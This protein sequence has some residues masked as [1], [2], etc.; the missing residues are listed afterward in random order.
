MRAELIEWEGIE[1]SRGRRLSLKDLT[2]LET[3]GLEINIEDIETQPNGTL[4]YQGEHVLLY[5]MQPRRFREKLNMPKYHISNCSTWISMKEK[6]RKDRYVASRRVDGLFELDI[7]SY[8]GFTNREEHALDVCQNCLTNV[9]WKGYASGNP[10][11]Y[12]IFR[13]FNLAEFFDV[14]KKSLIRER[15]RFTPATMPSANYTDDF[16]EISSAARAAA[17][18][19]CTDCGLSLTKTFERRFLHVH[20]L[21]GNKGDNSKDNLRVLCLGCHAEQP[22][23]RHMKKSPDFKMFEQL[24]GSRGV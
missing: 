17:K 10:G 21:S 2:A 23:H 3:V 11:R 4:T 24:F 7:P 18:W 1:P 14:Q 5:I 13:A 9:N 15:P 19:K 8:G 16:D 20:H 22:D 6:G 12:A